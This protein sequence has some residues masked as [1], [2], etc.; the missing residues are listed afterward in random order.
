MSS[1]TA[2]PAA[3]AGPWDD[4]G[5]GSPTG[6][7]GGTSAGA[8]SVWPADPASRSAPPEHRPPTPASA[9]WA[10]RLVP[11]AAGL[12]VALSSSALSGVLQGHRWF[13]YAL[14]VV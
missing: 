8:G 12:A 10:P 3:T 1:P 9:R 2:P 7:A 4:S 14:A 5:N 6:S 11:V 13:W